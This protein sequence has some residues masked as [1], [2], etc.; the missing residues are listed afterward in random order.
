MVSY[1][2]FLPVDDNFSSPLTEVKVTAPMM[3]KAKNMMMKIRR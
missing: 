2:E 3:K 1:A